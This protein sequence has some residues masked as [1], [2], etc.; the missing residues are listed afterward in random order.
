MLN[1]PYE[2]KLAWQWLD[3]DRQGNHK[4]KKVKNWWKTEDDYKFITA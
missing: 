2:N 3:S 4:T 1:N